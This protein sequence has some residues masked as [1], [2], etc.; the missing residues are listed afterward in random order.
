MESA[1]FPVTHCYATMVDCVRRVGFQVPRCVWPDLEFEQSAE[2]FCLDRA[3]YEQL[4]SSPLLVADRLVLL[5]S[6]L[7]TAI[8]SALRFADTI[9]EAKV[10]NCFTRDEFNALKRH[11]AVMRGHIAKEAA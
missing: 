5:Y 1:H 9:R 11:L 8:Y 6:F 7:L 3:Y 10:E 4:A 2:R